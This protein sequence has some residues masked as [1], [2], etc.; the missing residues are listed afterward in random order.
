[1]EAGNPFAQPPVS[2][3]PIIAQVSRQL[4][5][6]ALA[7]WPAADTLVDG[8]VDRVVRE[9]WDSRIKTFVPILALRESRNVLQG[10][11]ADNPIPGTA[12]RVS[13]PVTIS[14]ESVVASSLHDRSVHGHDTLTHTDHD[15]LHVSSDRLSI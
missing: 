13:S 1:M 4:R 5:A 2:P 8:V 6:E 12:V 15:T 3:D 7:D 14:P 9:L 10:A 11:R